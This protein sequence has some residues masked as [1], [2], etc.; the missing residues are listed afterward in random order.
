MKKRLEGIF[1]DWTLFEKVWLI[2]FTLIGLGISIAWGDSFIGFIA[3]ITGMLANILVAK[4][5]I[6]TY[7]FGAIGVAT[8]GYVA[9]GYG[10]YGEAML[11]WGFYFSANIIGFFM[12]NKNKK[13]AEEKLFGEDVPVK[14]LTKKG[15]LVV[16]A[17]FIIGSITYA[18]ILTT[19]NAQQVR[20]DSMA[21]VLS[22]IAQ[23]LMLMRYVEQW[24]LW[25]LVNI[26]S[27][28][29]WVVTLVQSGGNDYVMIIM[30]VSYLVNSIYGL[31]NWI[32][33]SK[34]N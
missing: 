34:T 5:K 20:L 29:L 1:K 16:V 33:L 8:Y 28:G 6:S 19:L 23:V 22:I 31:I 7:L 24:Y 2:S 27:I 11:N 15:W 12:W 10:L 14:K 26:L 30:W 17:L 3:T 18:F 9:F 13:Q 32:K 25:V 21:V 4:G